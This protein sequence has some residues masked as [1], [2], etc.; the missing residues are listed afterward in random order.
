MEVQAQPISL[1]IWKWG[2]VWVSAFF[3]ISHCAVYCC[4][5]LVSAL[6][7]TPHVI[8]ESLLS[9]LRITTDP[10]HFYKKVTPKPFSIWFSFRFVHSFAPTDNNNEPRKENFLKIMFFPNQKLFHIAGCFFA[11]WEF[12][13]SDPRFLPSSTPLRHFIFGELENIRKKRDSLRTTTWT[14]VLVNEISC[15]KGDE[16]AERG[17]AMFEEVLEWE[18]RRRRGAT[19]LST[20]FASSIHLE[21]LSTTQ[22]THNVYKVKEREEGRIFF[23]FPFPF[24]FTI[25]TFSSFYPALIPFSTIFLC[26]CAVAVARALFHSSV[27]RKTNQREI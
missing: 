10:S 27:P 25:E 26:C 20:H 1:H 23:P 24:Y 16:E 12:F 6:L 4:H 7:R 5:P 8:V 13:S 21:I 14:K 2:K 22:S 3:R 11:R 18:M 15:G 19:Q 9:P 17:E